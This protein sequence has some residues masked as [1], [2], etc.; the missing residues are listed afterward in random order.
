[1]QKAKLKPASPKPIDWYAPFALA[2]FVLLGLHLLA[3][4]G[5]RYTPW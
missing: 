4:F 1:M 3:Q 5:L 2:G